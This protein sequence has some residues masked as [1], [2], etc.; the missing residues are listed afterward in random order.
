MGLR[1]GLDRPEPIGQEQTRRLRTVDPAAESV[2]PQ[3]R[4]SATQIRSQ[5]GGGISS[6][7]PL[8]PKNPAFA[9]PLICSLLET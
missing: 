7:L 8:M 9:S 3:T 4:E 6:T 5:C 1:S 2:K